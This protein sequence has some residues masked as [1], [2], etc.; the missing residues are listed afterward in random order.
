MVDEQTQVTSRKLGEL[1][2][3]VMAKVE[4][5]YQGNPQLILDEW[6]KI[7]GPQIAAMARAERF[8]NSVLYVKVKNSTLLSLLNT[9]HDK[10]ELIKNFGKKLSGIQ[11]RNIVFRIG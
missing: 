1:L 8:E 3:K 5:N 7:V 9:P 11:I 2:L 4:A 6:P 10:K